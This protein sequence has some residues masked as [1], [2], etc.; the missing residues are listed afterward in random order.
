MDDHYEYDV[1]YTGE[2]LF[3]I[4][5]RYINYIG[6]AIDYMALIQDGEVTTLTMDEIG[7]GTDSKG[8]EVTLEY[9]T[10]LK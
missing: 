7:V 9:K 10:T 8:G 2:G 4:T 3:D 1:T 5:A 6:K